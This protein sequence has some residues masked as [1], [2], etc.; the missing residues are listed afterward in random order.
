MSFLV[1]V[2][3]P[4][5]GSLEIEKAQPGW[6]QSLDYPTL[7]ILLQMR[8]DALRRMREETPLPFRS[9]TP[10]MHSYSTLDYSGLKPSARLQSSMPLILGRDDLATASPRKA[11][12]TG[13]PRAPMQ[14]VHT[15]L[16]RTNPA[17]WY[18][19]HASI[20]RLI[21]QTRSPKADNFNLTRL[22]FAGSEH[23]RPTNANKAEPA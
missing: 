8:S 12:L 16:R 13:R 19:R 14:H 17:R 5:S 23:A 7:A 22:S 11:Q 6:G 1:D 20:P 3:E 15:A 2:T 10:Q 9:H 4:L 21:A 18:A